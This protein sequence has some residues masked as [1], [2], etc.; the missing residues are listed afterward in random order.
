MDTLHTFLGAFAT[1]FCF[2]MLLDFIGSYVFFFLE[3]ARFYELF[4]PDPRQRRKTQWS[5]LLITIP[6]AA[7]QWGTLSLFLAILV[8][9]ALSL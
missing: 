6:S 7:K 1:L 2:F 5:D 3:S 4:R 8:T 9:Y